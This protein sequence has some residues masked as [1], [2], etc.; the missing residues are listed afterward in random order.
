MINPYEIK[1]VLPGKDFTDKERMGLSKCGVTVPVMLDEKLYMPSFGI[2]SS[3][4]SIKVM[5]QIVKPYLR[6]IN[7]LRKSLIVQEDSIRSQLAALTGTQ[8][9][10]LHFKLVFTSISQCH[11]IEVNTGE[12]IGI[13]YPENPSET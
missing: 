4:H 8:V 3:G 6:K 9:L 11:V 2:A 1:G 12:V 5:D 7:Q 10:D 13:E